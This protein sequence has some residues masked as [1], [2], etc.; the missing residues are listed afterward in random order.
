MCPCPKTLITLSVG[1]GIL[2][3]HNAPVQCLEI[4]ATIGGDRDTEIEALYKKNEL[5]TLQYRATSHWSLQYMLIIIILRN[6]ANTLLI[7]MFIYKIEKVLNMYKGFFN[8]AMIYVQNLNFVYL[9]VEF[10]FGNVHFK[11]KK[12]RL[13]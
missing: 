1:M 11:D 10:A 6:T 12:K 8:L 7:F 9:C 2:V 3:H 5:Y 13:V 4:R